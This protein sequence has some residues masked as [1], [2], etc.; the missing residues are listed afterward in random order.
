MIKNIWEHPP[1]LE[2]EPGRELYQARSV[3]ADD[4]AKMGR[5]PYEQY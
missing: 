2:D 5:P 1:V 3:S 4:L